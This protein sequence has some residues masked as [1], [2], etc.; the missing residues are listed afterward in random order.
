MGKTMNIELSSGNSKRFP[1]K[2]FNFLNVS[3]VSANS[4][5]FADVGKVLINL[6]IDNTFLKN[7]P[8]CHLKANAYTWEY[9][10]LG[11]WLSISGKEFSNDQY[12]IL[13]KPPRPKDIYGKTRGRGNKK[14]KDWNRFY[15]WDL[16]EEECVDDK[17]L[18]L[19]KGV[20]DFCGF[21]L[22]KNNKCAIREIPCKRKSA[23]KKAARAFLSYLCNGVNQK[24]LVN[25]SEKERTDSRLVSL[26][27]Y[28]KNQELTN[29][30]FVVSLLFCLYGYRSHYKNNSDGIDIELG[31]LV[32]SMLKENHFSNEEF[33]D[34]L[35]YKLEEA[36]GNKRGKFTPPFTSAYENVK[37]L[38]IQKRLNLWLNLINEAFDASKI[39]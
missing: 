3:E 8:F 36:I 13:K 30:I 34:N 9:C 7:A 39:K 1:L 37:K 24:I 14:L 23:F 26:L 10:V 31:K 20:K 6:G 28:F 29:H 4:K 32:V 22:A 21:L 11:F 33:K 38:N 16:S 27:K 18:K 17:V 5:T 19:K 2:T 15:K 25:I 12:K 35:V